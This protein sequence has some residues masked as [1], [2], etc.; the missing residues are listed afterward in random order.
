MEV[1]AGMPADASKEALQEAVTYANF[2]TITYKALVTTGLVLDKVIDE[3]DLSQSADELAEHVTALS[4]LDT[5]VIEIIVSWPNARGAADVA[6]SI[7]RHTVD[8]LSEFGGAVSI[9]L[10]QVS[11]ASAAKAPA[12]PNP[13]LSLG[14]AVFAA[15]WLALGWLVARHWFVSRHTGSLESA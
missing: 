9:D 3:L 12:V 7:A 15:L 14:L 5:T 2:R 6:N 13:A 10:V 1:K 8:E 4:A 11:D